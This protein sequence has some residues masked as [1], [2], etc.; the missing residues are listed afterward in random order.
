MK[1]TNEIRPTELE[2]ITEVESPQLE[3]AAEVSN[4][5]KR[6]RPEDSLNREEFINDVVEIVEK[7]S[8]N[9]ES[10]SFAIDGKWGVGKTYVVEE[11]EERLSDKHLVIHYNA[12]ENDYYNEPLLS[13]LTTFA[14]EFNKSLKKLKFNQVEKAIEKSLSDALKWCA[15]SLS[16]KV[17]GFDIVNAVEKVKENIDSESESINTNIGENIGLKPIVEKVRAAIEKVSEKTTIVFVVDELDRC[18]PEYSIKVL[19]RLHHV[20]NDINNLQL[21]ISV[22][23]E[24]LVSTI[25]QIFGEK[26]NVENYMQKFIDFTLYLDEGI[27]SEKFNEQIIS[28]K[29]LFNIIDEDQFIN[30]FTKNLFADIDMRSRLNLVAKAELIHK[31]YFKEIKDV[32]C[33]CFELFWITLIQQYE[34]KYQ[35]GATKYSIGDFQKIDGAIFGTISTTYVMQEYFV[36]KFKLVVIKDNSIKDKYDTHEKLILKMNTI[37]EKSSAFI[38]L[39]VNLIKNQDYNTFGCFVIDVSEFLKAYPFFVEFI[40]KYN[41]KVE[42]IK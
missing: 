11:V 17:V 16:K 4:C 13:I 30:E 1:I 7:F 35:Y 39:G 37:S 31:T 33:M 19:E 34:L 21:I 5:N 10:K 26:R 25:Q 8:E 9:K 3:G 36:E 32:E 42:F 20:F 38:L 18:L 27:L 2:V 22:D 24:Q 40:G 23:K 14:D 12:W 28:Y 15:S 41:T 29:N 6:K